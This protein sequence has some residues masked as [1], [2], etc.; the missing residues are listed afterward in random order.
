MIKGNAHKY[1]ISALC[2]CLGV[3][4]AT[5]YRNYIKEPIQDKDA[6]LKQ[7]IEDIFTKNRCVFGARKIKRKLLTDHSVNVSVRRINRNMKELG[8]ESVYKK[9]KYKAPKG[10]TNESSIPNVLDRD[11]NNKEPYEAVVSDL[12]SFCLREKAT[13]YPCKRQ[14]EPGISFKISQVLWYLLCK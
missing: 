8:L 5:Y 12:Y 14:I 11:F 4:R 2:K 10:S 6:G 7:K 3:A 1:S 9:K 13:T